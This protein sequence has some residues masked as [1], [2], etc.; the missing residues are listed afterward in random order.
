MIEPYDKMRDDIISIKSEI[1]YRLCVVQY[2]K[3]IV[4]KMM[5]KFKRRERYAIRIH[6][7]LEEIKIRKKLQ[8]FNRVANKLGR[9]F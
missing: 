6:R 8:R 5:V 7:I 3:E 2:G 4:D 9:L 1:D